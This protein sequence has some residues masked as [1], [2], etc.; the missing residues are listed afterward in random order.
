MRRWSEALLAVVVVLGLAVG[1]FLFS[2]ETFGE[3][4]TSTTEPIAFDSEAAMRGQITAE[5]TGCLQCHTVDG[6]PS[7]SGPTWQGVAGASV[8]MTTGETIVADDAYLLES[9]VDP[10]ALIVEGFEPIMPPDYGETLST[11]EIDDLVEYIKSLS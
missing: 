8:T 4:T 5:S 9:I 11:Q 3:E 6:T 7:N 2:G 1:L 10:S